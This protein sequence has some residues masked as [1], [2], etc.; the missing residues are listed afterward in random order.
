MLFG[1]CLTPSWHMCQMGFHLRTFALAAPVSQ[2]S[3]WLFSLHHSAVISSKKHPDSSLQCPSSVLLH[4]CQF[5][6]NG[7]ECFPSFRPPPS[8]LPPVLS[9][10]PGTWQ[11]LWLLRENDQSVSSRTDV[12]CP[13]RV[14]DALTQA[15][16]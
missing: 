9:T 12:W 16:S 13:V 3:T 2:I 10:Q 15:A 11:A 4:A 7:L 8:L 6:F 1:P 5:F 14:V